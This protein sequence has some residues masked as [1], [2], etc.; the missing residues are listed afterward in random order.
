MCMSFVYYYPKIELQECK[1]QQEF[2]SFLSGLGVGEVGGDIL[3]ELKMPYE[4]K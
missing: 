4:P 2:K 3:Q 1:I